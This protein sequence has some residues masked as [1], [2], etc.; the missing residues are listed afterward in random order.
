MYSLITTIQTLLLYSNTTTLHCILRLL[1]YTISYTHYYTNTIIHLYTLYP[2]SYTG[3]RHALVSTFYN[4]LYAFDLDRKRWYKLGLKQKKAKLTSEDRRNTR[5]LQKLKERNNEDDED[6]SDTS[7]IDNS[8]NEDDDED[9]NMNDLGIVDNDR[10]EK[11]DF[12]GYIDET[13]NVVYINL[14]DEEEVGECDTTTGTSTTTIVAATGDTS[15]LQQ[16]H[17]DNTTTTTT[18]VFTSIPTTT[19]TTDT[20]R[21]AETLKNQAKYQAR[22]DK[23][24]AA[25][26]TSNT[27]TTT[28]D[29]TTVDSS[30]SD[31]LVDNISG[32]KA[33][34]DPTTAAPTSST[35][36]MEGEPLSAIAKYFAALTEPCPR[37]NPS[38]LIR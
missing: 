5:K 9:V 28:T 11:G 12:F 4:D 20:A 32:E 19:T 16:L 35:T 21:M 22:L 13:G 1:P 26:T 7:D 17:V 33:S 8:D 25:T 15:S 37:I 18:T 38:I 34:T 29:A 27:S 24:A 3:P 14:K 30:S 23:A 31:M 2:I 6:L 36:T 10:A